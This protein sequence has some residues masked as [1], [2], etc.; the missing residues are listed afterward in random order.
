[1]NVAYYFK[2][3]FLFFQNQEKIDFQMFVI[4]L[5]GQ[6]LKT[7]LFQI[8][9]IKMIIQ[10]NW[11]GYIFFLYLLAKLETIRTDF[12]VKTVTLGA[13]SLVKAKT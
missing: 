10:E 7:L 1:M 4:H 13:N 5:N 3:F 9:V 11:V 8:L 2:I 6:N 12:T